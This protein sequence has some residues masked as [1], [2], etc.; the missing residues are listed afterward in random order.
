MEPV[1]FKTFRYHQLNLPLRRDILH[2]AVIWEGDASRSGT[3]NTKHRTQVQGSMR[4]VRPQKG[5]GHAR[6]SDA[7]APHLRGGGV[8]HGPRARDFGTE[9]PSK[10]YDLAY[11]TA[12]SYRY[13][14]GELIVLQNAIGL[15]PEQGPRWFDNFFQTHEWGKKKGRTLL[16]SARPDES[17]SIESAERKMH[18]IN[19]MSDVSEHGKM[20]WETDADVKDI[21]SSGRI[22]IEQ[23]ALERLLTTSNVRHNFLEARALSNATFGR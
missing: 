2:R 18:A 4:K 5:T 11:R 22:I 10:M 15:L 16:I 23:E 9:L 6:L 13:N 1:S 8:V 20:Q 3:A 21:L 19:A 12:L 7:R 14:R 17:T